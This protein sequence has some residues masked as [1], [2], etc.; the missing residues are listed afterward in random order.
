MEQWLIYFIS[1]DKWLISTRSEIG[2]YNKWQ[3][4]KIIQHGGNV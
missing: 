3:D 4:L 2:G 1:N